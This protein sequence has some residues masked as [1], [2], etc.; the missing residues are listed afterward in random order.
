MKALEVIPISKG[1][2]KETFTYFTGSDVSIGD[3]IKVQLRK[4]VIPALVVST[5]EIE[6]IKS[7]IKSS[8]FPLKKIEKNKTYH[9]LKK[10]FVQ[11]A[12]ATASYY[13]GT[14]GAVLSSII[15][16]T[17]FE[18]IDKIKIPEENKETKVVVA[19]EKFVIQSNDEDRYAHYKSIIREE[20]AKNSSVFFCLPTIQDI[21]KAMEKLQKGIE[22]Y[23]FILH[24]SMSKKE[25]IETINKILAEDHPIL[26]IA[27]GAFFS[28]PKSNIS[29]II[30]DKENSRAYKV[31]SRPYVDIRYFAETFAQKINAKI[32]FG[33]LLLRAETIWR[34]KNAELV[35]IAPL[36]FRSL[37]TSSQEIIDM[38]NKSEDL[39]EEESKKSETKKTFKIFSDE[40]EEKIKE[41]IENNEHMFIFTARRG[42]SPSTLCADCGNIVKC[43]TCGAHTVLHKS[44]AENFFLCHKCGERRSALEKCSN[45]SG[46]RLTTLGI[47]SELVEEKIQEKYPNAKIFRIDADSTP[48][49]KRAEIM[50]EKF[51]NSPQGILIGTEMALLYLTEKV[52]NSAVVSMDSF[53]S[54]PDFRINERILNILLKIRAI[55]D[56][57]LIVQTRDAGQKVFEYAIK[58]NLVEFYRDEIEDRKM[59]NYPPFSNLIKISIVGTK[60][61]ITPFVESFQKTIEP[62]D[63]DIFPA[64]I[65][66]SK[67]KYGV[68]G[69]IKVPARDWPNKELVEKLKFLP[70]NYSVNIDPDSLI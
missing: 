31:Q 64:F 1:I 67:G 35:E 12:Q 65:P 49:H 16:K 39:P 48:T 56:K 2:S 38:R 60:N 25:I 7:E 8:P 53:F 20:F 52:E 46:W 50:A 6:D 55:T 32:I 29:T 41:S 70:M 44:P 47:G 19:P 66:Q 11:A 36:K 45:C 26:I 5:K 9:L 28:I 33:D 61:E 34:Y 54:I 10:E 24:G 30:L 63:I 42:L 62:Y 14:T 17:I 27:T 68:N 43:N 69:I 58:G 22:T 15:P 21:K 18:N 23:T 59:L 37:T 40:L 13:A 4:R 3:I 57:K 51:Y